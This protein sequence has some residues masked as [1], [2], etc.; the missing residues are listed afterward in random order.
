M[1]DRHAD[2]FLLGLFATSAEL[3]AYSEAA[4]FA[5]IFLLVPLALR[6]VMHRHFAGLVSTGDIHEFSR[7]L[8]AMRG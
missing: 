3:G 7:S 4:L 2:L 1:I 5:R 8:V 6:P